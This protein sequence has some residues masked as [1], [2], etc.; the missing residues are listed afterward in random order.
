MKYTDAQGGVH[1][2]NSMAEVPE[3]Y[4]WAAVPA[5]GNR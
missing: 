5:F 3:Q 2:F 1:Y 4:R